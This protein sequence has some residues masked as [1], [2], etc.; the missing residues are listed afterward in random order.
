MKPTILISE[1][2]GAAGL[3][4]LRAAGNCITEWD[5]SER[6]RIERARQHLPDADAVVVR[7]FEVDVD[8]LERAPRLRVIG[9]AGA[10]V[11]NIDCD[12]ATRQRI[13]IVYTPG[14]NSN[15]VAEHTMGLM[16]ALARHV[17][18]GTG[19]VKSGQPYLREDF[20][21]SE[22]AGKT[23]GVIGL[24]RIG[25]RVTLTAVNGF[26]MTVIAH[27]PYISREECSL[28]VTFRDTLAELLAEADFI[29]LH[30]PLTPETRGMIDRRTLELVRPGCRLVNT[31]RGP[32]VDGAA[33]AG[34]LHD[35]QLAGAGLDVFEEEPLPAGHPLVTA[36]NAVLTP[37]LAGSTREAMEQVSVSV[38]TDLIAILE[39]RVP[40]SDNVANPDVLA[41]P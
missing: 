41:G 3:A 34:A 1:P 35:G 12:A 25:S 32:V 5:G 11:D 29:T 27:D 10:G 30:V 9:K 16:L 6:D 2:I 7:L 14:V 26:G 17:V 37:H 36:P 38:A 8:A 19:V 18:D 39:G 31:S 13:P 40:A 15:A 20:V 4:M 33:V 23:L 21:G 28:P 24:G 22:L